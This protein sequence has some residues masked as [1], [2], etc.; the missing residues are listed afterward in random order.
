MNSMM[1]RVDLANGCSSFRKQL[2][3]IPGESG[4]GSIVSAGFYELRERP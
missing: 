2:L 4:I 3:E 1:I